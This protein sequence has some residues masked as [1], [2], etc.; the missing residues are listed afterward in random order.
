MKSIVMIIGIVLMMGCMLD[1]ENQEQYK[2]KTSIDP[3]NY[4]KIEKII[5]KE[6]YDENGNQITDPDIIEE[7]ENNS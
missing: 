2:A 7:I 6:Y 4:V 1:S 5:V 3:Y